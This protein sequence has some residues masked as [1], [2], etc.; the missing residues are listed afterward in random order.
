MHLSPPGSDVECNATTDNIALLRK[1]D[2]PAPT[3]Q[4]IL[5]KY[6]FFEVKLNA[7]C[8]QL[9]ADK[10]YMETGIKPRL[11]F[12]VAISLKVKW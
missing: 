1:G 7:Q 6:C 10:G 2:S 12:F 9:P 5:G 8:N 4:L 11:F 3:I